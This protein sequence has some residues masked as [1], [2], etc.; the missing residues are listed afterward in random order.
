MF[1]WIVQFCN[2]TYF[3]VRVLSTFSR[4]KKLVHFDG[5]C[6]KKDCLGS[7]WTAII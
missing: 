6:D 7:L 5:L 3:N 2:K 1:Y 4:I